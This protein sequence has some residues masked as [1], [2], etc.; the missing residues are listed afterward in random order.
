[1]ALEI[2]F[3]EKN[4][5]KE[6]TR[7]FSRKQ[8]KAVAKAVNG[9]TTP[10][11][12]ATTWAKGDILADDWLLECKTKTCHSD[13]IKINKE[14]FDK[15]RQEMAFMGK[16]YESIVFNFG[17]NEENHYIIDEY[18]FQILCEALKNE[19]EN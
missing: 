4:G 16:K 12:G 15:N 8:E 9:K 14:W 1:M 10:N 17:P 18:L 6:P 3:R 19:S 13:S 11:S 5:K 7:S 2:P